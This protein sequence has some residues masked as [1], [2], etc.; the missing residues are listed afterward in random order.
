MNLKFVVLP[1]SAIK[2]FK[3]LGVIANPNHWEEKAV[4]AGMV[5]FEKNVGR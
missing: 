1:V 5:T 2:A 4:G 3:I